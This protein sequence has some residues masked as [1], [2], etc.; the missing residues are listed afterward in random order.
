[1]SLPNNGPMEPRAEGL[2]AIQSDSVCS[3]VPSTIAG[4]LGCVPILHVRGR[5]DFLSCIA[6][7]QPLK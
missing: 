1:M 3:S 5:G 7:S 4:P 6:G 2:A